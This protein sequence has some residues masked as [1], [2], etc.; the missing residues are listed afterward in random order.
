MK[1]QGIV[2]AVYSVGVLGLMLTGVVILIL[3]TVASKKSDFDRKKATELGTLVMEEQVD[4]SKN[5]IN[6]FWELIN[7]S[8]K[9]KVEF[10]GFSYSIGFTNVTGNANY[11][12]C[13]VGVTNC[14]EVSVKVDWLGK[15]PQSMY[16]NR[17]F[18]KYGN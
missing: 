4:N 8:G 9:T 1:G 15:N 3:M 7:I 18:S 2:E 11:P 5:N 14:T 13:G 16:F 10:T 12:N 17:F 6:S